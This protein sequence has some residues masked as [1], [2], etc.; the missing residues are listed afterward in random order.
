MVFLRASNVA[1]ENETVVCVA[2]MDFDQQSFTPARVS[3]L[4]AMSPAT[5]PRPLEPGIRVMV[6]L[7]LFPETLKGTEWGSPQSHSQL[8]QPLRMG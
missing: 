3:T 2:P 8:P 5:M 6:T 4:F 1:S 7:P